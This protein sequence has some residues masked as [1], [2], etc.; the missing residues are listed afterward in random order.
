[1]LG[2]DIFPDDPDG[3]ARFPVNAFLDFEAQQDDDGSW[4]VVEVF[5]DGFGD[6]ARTQAAGLTEREALTVA[7]ILAQ[8][9]RLSEV[10]AAQAAWEPAVIAGLDA[11]EAA[12]PWRETALDD[13]DIPF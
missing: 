3:I 2:R 6:Y 12:R 8:Q 5:E 11:Y 7:D 1:M 9:G 4:R 13:D 10:Q